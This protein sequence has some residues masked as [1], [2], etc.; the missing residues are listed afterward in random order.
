MHFNPKWHLLEVLK[1]KGIVFHYASSCSAT[2][3]LE[4]ETRLDFVQTVQERSDLSGLLSVLTA[5]EEEILQPA[6]L[7]KCPLRG[8]QDSF[9]P[10]VAGSSKGLLSAQRFLNVHLY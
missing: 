5:A 3:W 6:E 9:A 8:P 10:N 4:D 7:A 1:P 2:P